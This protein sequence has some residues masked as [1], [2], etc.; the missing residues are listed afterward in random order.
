MQVASF[1]TP[2]FFSSLQLS[3]GHLVVR[4]NLGDGPHHLQLPGHRLDLGQWVQVGLYRYGNLFV[5]QLEQG[6]GD[7]EVQ[8]RLG[9]KTLLMLDPDGVTLGGGPVWDRYQEQDLNEDWE[10][11]Q[12]KNQDL[13]RNLNQYQQQG[14]D[15]DKDWD[16]RQI[17]GQDWDQDQNL[18]FQGKLGFRASNLLLCFHFCHVCP[19]PCRL[20]AGRACEQPV[21]APGWAE[22]GAGCCSGAAGSDSRLQQRSMSGP[23]M[24][25][26]TAL[27][28]P[29]EETP[30]Q[31]SSRSRTCSLL[32]NP[33]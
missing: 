2:T 17:Q 29:V 28:R 26:S 6:G 11:K 31:V 33:G 12:D 19:A 13:N 16:Q 1:L 20:P 22:P 14:H 5:L 8:A 3:E 15:Q 4:A 10:K 27:R 32:A 18:D 24:P 25:K 30:V 21:T 7:R 23:T 9:R